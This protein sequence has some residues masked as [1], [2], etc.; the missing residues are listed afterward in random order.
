M[1]IRADPEGFEI[2][3]L[4]EMVDLS[5]KHVLEIGSGSGRLTWRIARQ[6]AQVTAIEPFAPSVAKAL[7][8]LPSDLTRTV[9]IQ[10]GSFDDFASKAEP[11][12]F[13]AAILSWSLC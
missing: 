2:D 5:G 6:A 11:E 8:S 12:T 7:A 4:L 3:A 10:Q 13:D 9:Q 1:G